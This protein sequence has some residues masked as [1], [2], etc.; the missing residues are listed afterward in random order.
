[1]TS[2][3]LLLVARKKHREDLFVWS[4]VWFPLVVSSLIMAA[5]GNAT[6]TV[7][8]ALLML[9]SSLSRSELEE[10]DSDGSLDGNSRG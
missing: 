4:V 8:K 1:M 10:L 9:D 2:R 6:I 7:E 3:C 5:R